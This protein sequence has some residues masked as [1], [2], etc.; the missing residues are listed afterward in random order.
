MPGS[1]PR[2]APL[3]LGHVRAGVG[4]LR[5][6]LLT[7]HG[8][9]LGL[10]RGRLFDHLELHRRHPF[11]SEADFR[12]S[13]ARHVDDALSLRRATIIDPHFDGLLFSVLVTFTIVPNGSDGWAAVSFDWLKTS[14]LAVLRPASLSE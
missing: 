6:N 12:G 11:L 7:E 8:L 4:K 10:F 13:G 1:I 5:P 2:G 3:S 9:L 14:P